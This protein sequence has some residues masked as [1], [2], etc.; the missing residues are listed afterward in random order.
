MSA[1]EGAFARA[2]GRTAERED[3]GPDKPNYRRYQYDLI[4]P[5]CGRSVLEVGA[6]LGEF[7]SQFTGLDRLVVTDVDPDA[8]EVLKVRFTG[9]PE[10]EAAQF[11]LDAGSVLDRPVETVIAIN[12]LEHFEDDAAIL[13]LLARSVTPGGTIV[14][15]VPA[16][17]SL[18]GEFDRKVGHFRRYTPGTLRDAA[19]RAGLGVELCRPV[20]LLGGLAWWAAVRMGKAGSPKAGAVG[21]YDK[22]IVPVTKVLDRVLPI[23]FGQSVVGV[24]RVPGHG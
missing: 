12:V 24:L 13:T 20:N 3:G 23:P 9:R 17:Q 22:V 19:R 10:V 15:W 16:Y 21:L 6:G 1:E 5:H 8:V 7:A 2:T 4:S 14:L 18:Y 11:D